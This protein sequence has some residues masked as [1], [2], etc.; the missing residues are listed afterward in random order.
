MY[1]PREILPRLLGRMFPRIVANAKEAPIKTKYRPRKKFYGNLLKGILFKCSGRFS[2]AQMAS[3]QR[4]HQG[5]I[6]L[7]SISEK[8]QYAFGTISLKY[9][10]LG[11]KVYLLN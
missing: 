10:S 1:M 6:P 4:Y 11:L 2:R 9:G 3:Q 7:S 8:V 5:R